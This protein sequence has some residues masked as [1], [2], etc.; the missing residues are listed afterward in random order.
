MKVIL[1]LLAI[2]SIL[3]PSVNFLINENEISDYIGKD[4]DSLADFIVDNLYLFEKEYNENLLPDEPKFEAS[5]CEYRTKIRNLS[6]GAD[7]VYLDFDGNNGYMVIG[8]D[9]NI[10]KFEP[11]GD[12]AFLKLEENIFYSDGDG[13]LYYNEEYKNYIPYETDESEDI[14]CTSSAGKDTS[15]RIVDSDAYINGNYGSGYSLYQSKDLLYYLPGTQM[16]LTM[17]IKTI[18][19]GITSEGNCA[20]VSMYN[21]LEYLKL[22]NK[23]P[24]LPSNSIYFR[25][26]LD[27]PHYNQII[28]TTEYRPR[29]VQEYLP[30]LYVTIR[31]HAAQYYSYRTSNDSLSVSQMD[32]F[33]EAIGDFY[34]ANINSTYFPLW[35][36]GSNVKDD[37]D[38]GYFTIFNMNNDSFY[39]NHSVAVAGYKVYRKATKI[40]F[41][42]VYDTVNLAIIGDGWGPIKAYYDFKPTRYGSFIRAR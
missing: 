30:Q 2:L 36:F 23:Y 20:L 41:V 40:L 22:S 25:P 33:I 10:Y 34:G 35:S 38:A 29:A 16:E 15:G 37:I 14:I 17:Y 28:S 9:Y 3:F 12:L 19:A 32:N 26:A 6:A 13:F 18:G 11:V 1:I 42:T 4:C 8:E 21:T 24:S 5:G 27:D 31:N 39:G 7:A